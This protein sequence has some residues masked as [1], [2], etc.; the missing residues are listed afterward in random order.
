MDAGGL[1]APAS[2]NIKFIKGCFFLSCKDN[3]LMVDIPEPPEFTEEELAKAKETGRYHLIFFEWYKFVAQISSLLACI[4]SRS[5]VFRDVPKLHHQVLMGL[6]NRCARLMLA[7]IA[8]SHGGK[9]G[10][11]TAIIERSVLESSPPW[12]HD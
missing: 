8:L 7:N 2:F 10:E 9:F 4:E 11:S 12:R 1:S 5:E 3:Q 6:M